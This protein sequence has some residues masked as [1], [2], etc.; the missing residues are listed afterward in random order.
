MESVPSLKDYVAQLEKTDEQRE[1]K[2][3]KK[4]ETA[5]ARKREAEEDAA[6]ARAE[7][8]KAAAV[9]SLNAAPRAVA[10]TPSFQGRP[11]AQ[12]GQALGP[13][14]EVVKDEK[15]LERLPLSGAKESWLFGREISEVDFGLQHHSVSRKHA[16][17]TRQ[18]NH[19]FITDMGSVHGTFMEGRRLI[20]K[21]PVRI[22]SGASFRLGASTRNYIYREP[23]MSTAQMQ[24]MV[25]Q[26]SALTQSSGSKGS[27]GK[28]GEGSGSKG[29]GGKGGENSGRFRYRSTVGSACSDFADR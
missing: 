24:A 8:A 20:P 12:P 22:N 7:A 26:H 17:L 3:R 14:L 9:V 2:R 18:G 21:V 25:L 13:F 19:L 15:L 6:A 11:L 23:Q 5:A 28:G 29:S 16:A 1:A 27:S 10:S 4:E